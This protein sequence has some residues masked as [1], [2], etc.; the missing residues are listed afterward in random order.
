MRSCPPSR[1]WCSSC[2]ATASFTIASDALKLVPI[3]LHL[4]STGSAP[5]SLTASWTTNEDNRA[6]PFPLRRFFIPWADLSNK[7]TEDVIPTT[8]P[9][10]LEGG[11]WAR[12]YHV[13]FGEQAG[14]S[15]CHTLY[16]RGENIGPDLS[17]L[18]H[19]D[20]TSV[21]RDITHPSFAINPDYL[22]YS[23]ILTDGRTLSGVVHNAGDTI[24]L[25]DTNGVKTRI[26]NA[27]VEEM[28]PSAVSTMPEGIAKQL[29]PDRLRD[30]MTFL[31]TPPPHMPRDLP[32]GR[33]KPRTLAEVRAVL[34]GTPNPAEKTRP[35]R[36][37]LV[38]GVKDHGLGEHD[39]PAWQL[40]WAELLA[41][42]E[43]VEVSTAWEWPDKD[44]FQKADV[45]I[46]YQH[47]D[48][49]ADRA[50]DIDAFLKRGGGLVYIHWALDGRSREHGL[51]FAN[52]I[53]LAAGGLIGFRH[54]ETTLM[55]NRDTKHPIIRNFSTL[56]LTDETYW[57]LVGP[58]PPKNVLAT[59]LE[60]SEQRPQLWTMEHGQ[61]RVFVSIPGH[62]SWTFD[63][64][65]FR[66]LL[67]RAIAWT[68]HEPVDRFNNLIWPGAEVA[69]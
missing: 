61:G 33:P 57:H 17:N 19:R 66:V 64:P 3:E 52:R 1:R 30:L 36:I 24:E 2:A 62:Y 14:C 41:A 9:P 31:V 20:Y 35:I 29:G 53:G 4:K 58:L 55:F 5:P 38:A 69:K 28:T 37:A 45:M 40:A 16:S 39:Y 44:A 27:D 8:R 22:S 23:V 60:E 67:L 12:G 34:D 26:P 15:K 48:W 7:T 18:I 21:L 47:G 6:R 63:D 10:E 65:L 11:S 42:A 32:Q 43:H 68:A 54:G 49:N 50:A 56:A 59:A 51:E 25:G 13:F 46:F